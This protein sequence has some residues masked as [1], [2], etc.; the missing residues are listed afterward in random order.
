MLASL[1]LTFLAGCARGA[2]DIALGQDREDL[3]EVVNG[4]VRTLEVPVGN[5]GD[6]TLIIE[7][8]STSCGCTSAE[9]DPATIEPGETGTLRITYDSGA[10]GPEAN[11]LVVRQIFIASNDPD[12]PETVFE[13]VA[14]VLPADS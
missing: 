9:V 8:V 10:H 5:E 7:A 3:G 1:T 4:E 12:Q 6:G 14:T 11:G 2:P 13:F